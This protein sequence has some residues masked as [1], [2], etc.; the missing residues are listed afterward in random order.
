MVFFLIF[1]FLV[2]K[3][4]ILLQKEKEVAFFTIIVFLLVFFILDGLKPSIFCVTWF[5]SWIRNSWS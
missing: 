1:K 2:R 4:W 5:N 3:L